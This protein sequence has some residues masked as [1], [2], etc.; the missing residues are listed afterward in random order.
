[1]PQIFLHPHSL[2][3]LLVP[4]WRAQALLNFQG[5]DIE[6]SLPFS[7]VHSSNFL[8]LFSCSSVHC[9]FTRAELQNTTGKFLLSI[10][11]PW[12]PIPSGTSLT[13]TSLSPT[14]T[15]VIFRG[16]PLSSHL[17]PSPPALDRM[18]TRWFPKTV[19]RNCT[20]KYREDSLHCQGQ[21]KTATS[22]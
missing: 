12:C 13:V 15:S 3:W 17:I 20:V 5:L 19:W 22:D 1:M 6:H 11:L 10:H 7:P 18:R 21:A 2:N 9:W 16:T 14:M 8:C 4:L